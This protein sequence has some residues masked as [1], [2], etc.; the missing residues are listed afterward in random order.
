MDNDNLTIEKLESMLEDAYDE[1]ERIKNF[2]EDYWQRDPE[3][4]VGEEMEEEI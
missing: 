3:A 4:S 2:I 1:V